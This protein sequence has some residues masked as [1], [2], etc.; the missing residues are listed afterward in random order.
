MKFVWKLFSGIVVIVITL[1]VVAL[2]IKDEYT[3]QRDITINKPK[4]EVFDYVKLLNNQV[5][6]NKW[7][8][9]DPKVRRTS[10]G[11]DGTAGFTS[12]WESDNKKVG[13]GEQEIKQLAEGDSLTLRLHI[14]KPYESLA[15]VAMVTDSVAANQTKLIWTFN[16]KNK[17]PF[18][19]MNLFL[20]KMLGNDMDT[21]LVN[22]KAVMEK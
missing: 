7:V 15:D 4:Q 17:Y 5:Y 13:S 11:T 18:N 21:S 3:V 12:S 14:I 9:M 2:F 16:G 6:Y 22:L 8:M 20:D 19:L 10:T 1:L